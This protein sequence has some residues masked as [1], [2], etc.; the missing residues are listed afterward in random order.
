MKRIYYYYIILALFAGTSLDASAQKINGG[1]RTSQITMSQEGDF[2]LLEM[3]IDVQG[4]AVPNCQ[5]ITIAPALSSGVNHVRFPYVQVNG[6]NSGKMYA[7]KKKFRN[8]ALMQ[9]LPLE[10]VN[11]DKNNNRTK[12]VKYSAEVAYQPW[13]QEALF[14]ME[15][16]LQSCAGE[17]QLYAVE[18]ST[19]SIMPPGYV[20]EPVTTTWTEPVVLVDKSEWTTVTEL[21]GTVTTVATQYESGAAYLDFETSSSVIMPYFRRNQQELAKFQAAMDGIRMDPQAEIVQVSI[22]GYASPEA[23]FSTNEVLSFERARSF[24]RYVQG[25]YGISPLVTKVGSVGEDWVTL[26]QMIVDSDLPNKGTVLSIIDNDSLAPD[27]KESKLRR[28]DGGR[29]WRILIDR[30]FPELRRVEYKIYY[31]IN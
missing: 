11:L 25:K 7:R 30:M 21:P 19:V 24:A 27:A 12:K 3:I 8:T 26:R 9:D 31:K 10:V 17:V 6:N 28:L 14:D 4:D 20:E 18:I 23:R 1:I 29:Q 2:V 22:V 16:M 15:L 13:M 5:G